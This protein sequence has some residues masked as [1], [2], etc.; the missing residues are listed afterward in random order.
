[1]ATTAGVVA[2]VATCATCTQRW[3]GAGSTPLPLPL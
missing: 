2:E 3:D 1:L